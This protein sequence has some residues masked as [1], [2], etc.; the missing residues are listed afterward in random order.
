MV[1]GKDCG[2]KWH[3]VY[4]RSRAEKK[5]EEEFQQKGIECY[6]PLHNKLRQWKDR[7][8]WVKTPLLAG[9]CFVCITPKEYDCV[10]KTNNVVCYITFG[11]KAAVVREEQINNLKQMLLQNEFD[12][13]VANKEFSIGKKA[14]IIRGP[15]MGII[16]ELLEIRGKHKFLLRIEQINKVLIVELPKDYV[17][18]VPVR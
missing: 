10:L 9:Y 14:E 3:V 5:V 8:K 4:T 18:A 17:S 16:G 2:K 15:L 11:G 7:K 13:E 12:I 1:C 6:L